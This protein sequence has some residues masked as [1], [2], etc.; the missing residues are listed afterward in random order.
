MIWLIALF[1]VEYIWPRESIDI[2]EEFNVEEYR[3]NPEKFG[4]HR[5]QVREDAQ[6]QEKDAASNSTSAQTKQRTSMKQMQSTSQLTT[7]DEADG[8]SD[9]SRQEMPQIDKR[10]FFEALGSAEEQAMHHQ[11]REPR[12]KVSIL[13]NSTENSPA[14]GQK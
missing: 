7:S 8:S 5:F 9:F 1:I 2:A 6:S 11:A 13:S 12:R 4:S 10:L 3:A 14:K